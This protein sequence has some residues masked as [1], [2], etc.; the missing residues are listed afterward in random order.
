MKILFITNYFQPKIG[1]Q[2]YYLSKSFK[3]LGHDCTVVTSDRF[4]PFPSY[5]K[6]FKP[7]LG[8]RIQKIGTRIESGIRTTRL[9]LYFEIQSNSLLLFKNLF[10]NLR[11][12]KYDLLINCNAFSLS[13][14]QVAVSI[15]KLKKKPFVIFDS[16]ASTFNTSINDSITKRIYFLI[17]SLLM[18]GEILKA[19]DIFAPIGE[20]E[21][22][23][24]KDVFKQDIKSKIIPLG[25]NTKVFK[26][27]LN[28]RKKT[29]RKLNINNENLIVY[30]GK[31]TKNKDILVLIDSIALTFKKNRDIKLLI[32]GNG[33]DEYIK[34]ITSKIKK[35]NLNSIVIFKSFVE[36][37]ELPKYYNAGD[38]GV[39]PGDL[40]NTI[41]EAMATGLP[42]ILP[43]I[44]SKGQTT[45]HLSLNG[46]ALQ[47]QR[48]NPN[49]LSKN[50]LKLILDSKERKIRSKNCYNLIREKY[51]WDVIAQQY[52]DL[53][54][55]NRKNK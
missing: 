25:A 36:N 30:A 9:P 10:K 40:S 49:D 6:T 43:K 29:R 50:I 37:S 2:E 5:E 23:L 48:R 44:V 24:L 52:I 20:S 55:L 22:L 4:F 27:D 34:E 15:N 53:Y 51:S 54:N 13:N 45:N 26:P 46:A 21:K 7:I 28:L 31:I 18:K 35:N 8:N 47:F 11:K 38:I 41:Q 33:N 14:Y 1:Y 16:H 32:I 3:K 17:F 39:W 19:A 42:V 12:E